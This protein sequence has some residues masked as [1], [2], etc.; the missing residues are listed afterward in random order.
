MR[1]FVITDLYDGSQL[2]TAEHVCSTLYGAYIFQAG[3][4]GECG[5][6]KANIGDVEY[7]HWMQNLIE[8]MNKGDMEKRVEVEW[9]KY[10]EREKRLKIMDDVKSALHELADID[11][12]QDEAKTLLET[13][14]A[15][16]NQDM[17]DLITWSNKALHVVDE[18]LQQSEDVKELQG[19]F[20]EIDRL[21]TRYQGLQRGDPN[22]LSEARSK[23]ERRR[24]VD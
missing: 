16:Y 1:H 18:R 14:E 22:A 9:E 12:L 11:Q 8:L 3:L 15:F 24:D 2:T 4:N 10:L 17:E 13:S 5:G 21:V 23:M 19:L 20:K 7:G 6:V